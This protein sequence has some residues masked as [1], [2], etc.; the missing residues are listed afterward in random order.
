MFPTSY[1]LG[2]RLSNLLEDYQIKKLYAL[3]NFKIPKELPQGSRSSKL[4]LE[5]ETLAS[6]IAEGDLPPC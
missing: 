4:L 6:Q 5:E 1:V 3:H 2:I